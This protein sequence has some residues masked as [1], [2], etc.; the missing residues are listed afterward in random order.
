MGLCAICS[1]VGGVNIIASVELLL[2]IYWSYFQ[3]QF[4]HF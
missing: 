3:Y 4:S 1:N 2:N